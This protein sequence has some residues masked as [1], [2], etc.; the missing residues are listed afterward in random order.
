[1]P[2][3]RC[4]AL[5]ALLLLAGTVPSAAQQLRLVVEA[6]FA[7][8]HVPILAA[9]A[10]GH[11]QREGIDAIV[12]PGLGA[13]MVAVLVGQRAFELGHIPASA[14]AA[15]VARGTPIRMVAIHQP[16]TALSLVG[17]KG[18]ARLSGPKSV[19]GQRLG[20]T[21]GTIDTVALALF[22][23]T[24]GIGISAMTIVPTDRPAKLA[25][26]IAGRLD[27]VI[28]DGPA[29]RAALLEQGLEPEILELADQGVPFMGFG[30]I[31]HQTTISASPDL[32]RR[33]LVALR[34][35]Y[36]EAASD[37]RAACAAT[38][39]RYALPG[40]VDTC[41]TTLSIF[42]AHVA[43]PQA[44]GWGRQTTEAW[45]AMIEALRTAGEVQGTRP[46]SAYFS[47]AAIP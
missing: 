43:S 40:S 41:A 46:P 32:L 28:G 23:R 30:F 5:A 37:P 24:H 36:A 20:M 6:A 2:R 7:P 26:L 12:E 44:P 29:M 4:L 45:Q 39:A 22:R 16:R 42:M 47:N 21:P 8:H 14:A 33:A 34:A 25:E 31:A 17:V 27:V 9:V 38:H 35:G 1:M 13:N 11:F 15:A 10:R 18:R 3:T 19:E